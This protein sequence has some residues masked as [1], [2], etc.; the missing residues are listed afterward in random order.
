MSSSR[1]TDKSDFISASKSVVL[2]IISKL[3]TTQCVSIS[4]SSF[5]V[6]KT[7]A[8]QSKV[9]E[10]KVE[11]FEVKQSLRSPLSSKVKLNCI[12][13]M[14]KAE[15]KILKD[16]LVNAALEMK[17]FPPVINE[18][19]DTLQHSLYQNR[20]NTLVK[21]YI[22]SAIRE[23]V[24]TE[25]YNQFYSLLQNPK[26]VE[27]WNSEFLIS[28]INH[29]NQNSPQKI[30]IDQNPVVRATIK[31]GKIYWQIVKK[32]E[33]IYDRYKEKHKEAKVDIQFT[34][35]NSWYMDWRSFRLF[36][37]SG[38]RSS[39]VAITE[40]LFTAKLTESKVDINYASSIL[41]DLKDIGVINSRDRLSHGWRALSNESVTLKTIESLQFRTIREAKSAKTRMYNQIASIIY[42]I[43][44]EKTNGEGLKMITGAIIYRPE[45]SPKNWA[46]TGHVVHRLPK[47]SENCTH[48]WDVSVYDE[49]NKHRLS[50][51]ETREYGGMILNY[52]HIPSTHTLLSSQNWVKEAYMRY[53]YEYQQQ[54]NIIAQQIAFLSGGQHTHLTRQYGNLPPEI[55][56]MQANCNT[57]QV[58][59]AKMQKFYNEEAK[60]LA[61][62]IAIPEKLHKQGITYLQSPKAQSLSKEHPFLRDVTVYLDM[63]E[64][65]PQDFNLNSSDDYLRAIGAFRYLYRIQCKQPDQPIAEQYIGRI[66]HTFFQDS[67]IRKKI[68]KLFQ[69]RI[70]R[71][72]EKREGEVHP[73]LAQESTKRKL[74]K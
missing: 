30:E 62:S 56:T 4:S 46:G 20:D 8:S 65:R 47:V 39:T 51:F 43:V 3:E 33:V 13:A 19:M 29:L 22:E 11:V 5:Q 12:E 55:L 57:I 35:E 73:C 66:S 63:L 53:I 52:D 69:E 54:Y 67:E 15:Q 25:I 26:D 41:K 6:T 74:F 32:D 59:I 27:S 23:L 10:Q 42:S 68:D 9:K 72:M 1:P 38:K 64:E 50:S 45:R 60:E 40:Q 71:F 48:L 7:L 58:T 44:N 28:V 34:K 37:D 2:P 70:K 31:D 16:A 18:K 49:L 36:K 24:N 21:P 14:Q 17:S 61:F